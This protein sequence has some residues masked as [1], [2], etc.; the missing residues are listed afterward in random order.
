MFHAD[1][2]RLVYKKQAY[3]KARTFSGFAC[4]TRN[5]LPFAKRRSVILRVALRLYLR[6]FCVKNFFNRKERK[7]C[8]RGRT[9]KELF[10]KRGI[11][12]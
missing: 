4:E 5:G 6:V 12:K 3:K 9:E 10:Y 2:P 7:G 1:A 11:I 8:R